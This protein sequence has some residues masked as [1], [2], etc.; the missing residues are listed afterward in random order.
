MRVEQD[1][2]V[3]GGVCGKGDLMDGAHVVLTAR[4]QAEN[5]T[6]CPSVEAGQIGRSQAL[7]TGGKQKVTDSEKELQPL[8]LCLLSLPSPF[9][10]ET[11]VPHFSDLCLTS[12]PPLGSSQTLPVRLQF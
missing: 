7:A 3:S 6:M 8:S 12:Q 1:Q 2:E 4:C 9:C 10:L 11:S 5:P